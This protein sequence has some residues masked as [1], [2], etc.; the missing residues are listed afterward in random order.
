MNM[1]Q[2]KAHSVMHA[3]CKVTWT[4]KWMTDY[5]CLNGAVLIIDHLFPSELTL[6][7]TGDEAVVDYDHVA[8]EMKSCKGSFGI[9]S[10]TW[11]HGKLINTANPLDLFQLT[12]LA[13]MM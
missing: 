12:V 13:R 8:P 5:I 1:Q 4:Q 7:N 10:M 2:K 6:P 9:Q 11:V 3:E